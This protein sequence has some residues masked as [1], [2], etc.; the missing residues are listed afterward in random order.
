MKILAFGLDKSALEIGSPLA[1]RLVKYGELIERYDL[2]V[3]NPQSVKKTLSVKV[4]AYGSGGK[5]K[6]LQLAGLKIQALRLIL[7]NR[8]EVISVQDQYFLGFLAWSLARFFGLGMEVQVHGWEKKVGL[9]LSVAKFLINRADSVR[10]VSERLKNEAMNNF[11][12]Q[13]DKITVAPIFS[14]KP[15]E[16]DSTS[17][18]K[19]QSDKFVF[20]TVSRLVPVKNIGLQIR[21]LKSLEQQFPQAELWI[22]G[23]GRERAELEKT[24]AGL[25]LNRKVK[26]LGWQSSAELAKIYS[27]ADCFLLT[28][29][30][31]GYGLV[32]M[33]AAR[34]GLPIIMTDVGLAGEFIK[35]EENG[36]VIPIGDETAL[37]TAMVRI[38]AD[39]SLA[40]RLSNNVKTA[41]CNLPDLQASLKLYLASW[42]R[43]ADACHPCRLSAYIKEHAVNLLIISAVVAAAVFVRYTTLPF[44]S[45]ASDSVQ[46][47]E[48]ARYFL[49]QSA[50]AYPQ[51]ILKPLAPLGISLISFLTGGNMETA[52][53]AEAAL[54][55][56]F[57]GWAIYYLL[58]LF[59]RD[60]RSALL[61]SIVYI[62][63][64]PLLRFGLDLYTETG[65][66]FF[67][68]WAIAAVCLYYKDPSRFR[69]YA[70]NAIVL[71]GLLWKEYSLLG[72]VL[73]WLVIFFHPQLPRPEKIKKII[74]SIAMVFGWLALTQLIVYANYHYS[75]FNWYQTGTDISGSTDYHPYFIIKSLIAVYLL[76]WFLAILGLFRW[77]EFQPDQKFFIKCL[78]LP[79][80]MFL[81]WT[82]VSSRLYYVAAP[83]LTF[84]AVQGIRS[85]RLKKTAVQFIII[86]IIVAGSFFWLFSNDGFRSLI[87]MSNWR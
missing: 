40:E 25:N 86:A 45:A 47:M 63:A 18:E 9:R 2:I 49:G 33:E 76:G 15:L 73:L 71:I 32:V 58:N 24:V 27:Q 35:N 17:V 75:Y 44:T 81:L 13:P 85:A 8:Y 41:A 10:V 22:T 11:G 48:T 61:G 43:A 28:S 38:M 1:Q 3:P 5:Y 50:T 62:T 16:L 80:M 7:K 70:S 56:L 74:G 64:Y 84:L 60:K 83:L 26:F 4:D 31:E 6:I 69:Y 30:E 68:V 55:Y 51:R 21:A 79:S 12:V 37:K 36:L 52:L 87:Q 59:F 29:N 39:K 53:L 66:N 67:W 72:A 19:R 65:A 77:R 54:M 78:I 23:E 46:Y 14:S 34:Y 82:G 57:L 20:L 42:K